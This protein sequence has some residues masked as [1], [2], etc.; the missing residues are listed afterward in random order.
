MAKNAVRDPEGLEKY[1]TKVKKVKEKQ[2]D[3]G[4]NGS[5]LKFCQSF[6]DDHLEGKF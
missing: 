4:R 5:F 2:V 1:K 6:E 3:Q